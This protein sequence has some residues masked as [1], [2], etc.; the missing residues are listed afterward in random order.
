[1]DKL[2]FRFTDKEL[3]EETGLY[4]YGAR[5]LDPKYSRWMSGDPA[6]NDYI[7]K[8]P[9]DDEAKKHNEDLPGMGG[10]FNVVN[11][12]VYHY[13]GNNPVKYIDPDGRFLE[14]SDNGDGTYTVSGGKENSDKNIYL[15]VNGQRTGDIIGVMF[16]EHSFFNGGK[17]VA[18]AVINP[19]DSSGQEFLNDFK[20]NTPGLFSYIFSEG[21]TG[22]KY[23]FKN[24]GIKNGDNQLIYH[25]RGMP[26][27]VDKNG[28]KI[29]GTARDVGNYA[30]GYIA[31][32]KGLSWGEARF[33]FDAL[34]SAVDSLRAR[35]ITRSTE[36][37]ESRAAQYKGFIDGKANFNNVWKN[38][39]VMF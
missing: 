3:D 9:I 4:Y 20:E 2:P 34:Q 13:A 6:L 14:V 32:K 33:G 7:P 29:F 21:K 22:K 39:D 1:M 24:I 8:A 36:G 19:N 17:V 25:H 18:G 15:T 27:G 26:L 35:S 10:V 38:L 31:G 28:S 12:H 37:P 11:L 16:T 5:Y 23:D 30:A